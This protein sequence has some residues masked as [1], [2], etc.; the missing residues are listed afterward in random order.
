M[1]VE[2]GIDLGTSSTLICN[3]K[4]E[5]LV[6]EPSLVIKD[7]NDDKIVAIGSDASE[8]IGRTPEGV[9]AI[10]PVRGGAITGYNASVAMLKYFIKKVDTGSLTRVRAVMAVPCGISEVERRAAAEAAHGAGI[11]DVCLIEAPLAAAAGCGVEIG[12]PKGCMVVNIG[13]GIC[14]AAVVSLGGIVESHSIRTAGA[15][16][17]NGIVQYVKRKYNTVIG[18]ST[19]EALKISI[20]SVYTGI[21]NETMEV[22]GRDMVSGLPK[23]A[24]ISGSELRT[25]LTETADSI[26]DAVKITLEKTPPELAADIMKSGIVLTGGGAMLRGLGRYINVN[27]E[28]PVYIAEN[29][30]DCVAAGAGRAVDFMFNMRGR[31]IFGR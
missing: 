18:D 8:M 31:G 10:S 17:D 28:I 13:A 5:V 11:K 19:A 3:E 24:S 30:I 29:P 4:G 6:N 25:V 16:F 27:T 9:S 15:S 2:I 14:E 22:N 26:L 21:E 12:E 23:T 1:A 7:N 20:G